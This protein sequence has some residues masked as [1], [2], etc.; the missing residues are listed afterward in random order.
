MFSVKSKSKIIFTLIT[1]LVVGFVYVKIDRSTNPTLVTGEESQKYG[2][3]ITDIS[4]LKAIHKGSTV[5]MQETS[6][7]TGV[8][9]SGDEESPVKKLGVI[10]PAS[11]GNFDLPPENYIDEPGTFKGISYS[12]PSFD[13]AEIML[14]SEMDDRE[15]AFESGAGSANIMEFDPAESAL[16]SLEDY[17]DLAFESGAESTDVIEI[18]PARQNLSTG[19]KIEM[20]H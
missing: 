5:R 17:E 7:D 9:I 13:P 16:N 15:L 3:S 18:D 19:R 8:V 14:D 2:K 20:L 10:N 1:L 6:E 4:S 12:D 11:K